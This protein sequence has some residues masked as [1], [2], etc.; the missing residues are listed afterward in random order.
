MLLHVLV[1]FGLLVTEGQS[2]ACDNISIRQKKQNI[3]NLLACWNEDQAN[4]IQDTFHS[5]IKYE[6]YRSC[7]EI[8]QYDNNAKDGI[9]SL[10]TE[11]GISYQ[12]FCDMTTDGG[13][14]TLV[15]SIH[16]NNINGKCTVGDRWSSQQGNNENNPEGDGNWANYNTFG[17]ADGAT[18]DDYKNPGYYDIGANNVGLWHV[19][20]KTPLSLWKDTALLRYY[21]KSDILSAHGGN[22]FN[23]YK[24]YP[25]KFNVGTCPDNNGPS[26][27]VVYDKGSAQE[28]VRLN[29]PNAKNEITGGFIQFRVINN[30]KAAIALCPGMKVTNRCNAE[31]YCIGGGGYFPEVSPR[32]CGD[33][34]ALDWNGVGAHKDW[35][36][37]KELTDAAV[38]IFYR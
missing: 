35:S 32:Q 8:H 26:A 31:H 4:N 29:A 10:T 36:A 11:H 18:S 37:S 15:A 16:E 28:T 22:L 20:N 23:L 12:T 2:A 24:K 33:F 7:R 3:L 21:T 1:F 19:P 25:V 38:L 9:Y 5:N 34:P 17:L 27:P 13:G 14:W 6:R 30:E